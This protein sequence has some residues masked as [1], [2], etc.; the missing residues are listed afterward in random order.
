MWRMTADGSIVDGAG[1]VHEVGEIRRPEVP[2]E[3]RDGALNDES[4]DQGFR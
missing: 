2:V 4:H 3:V 1:K